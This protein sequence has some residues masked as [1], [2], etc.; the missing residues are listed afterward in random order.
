LGD[1]GAAIANFST[2]F[3]CFAAVLSLT[4]LSTEAFA[5]CETLLFKWLLEEP[6]KADPNTLVLDVGGNIGYFAIYAGMLGCTVH[7]FEPTPLP[8]TSSCVFFFF[9]ASSNF[10]H[11]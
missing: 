8:S 6:C 10:T 1:V 2:F 9:F 3:D 4:K 7:T 11:G 5:P